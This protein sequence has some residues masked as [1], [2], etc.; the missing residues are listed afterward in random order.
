MIQIKKIKLTPKKISRMALALIACVIIIMAVSV[1]AFLYKNFYQTIVQSEEIMILRE[2]VAVEMVDI[3]KFNAIISKF[4]EKTK[5][6][7]LKNIVS[8]FR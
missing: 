5:T 3:D 6:H 4:A 1:S 7:E 2:K 8:P